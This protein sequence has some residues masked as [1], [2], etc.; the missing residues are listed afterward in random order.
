MPATLW[1]IET[2][3]A[4]RGV[5]SG[6]S[7]ARR[8]ASMDLPAPGGPISSR[9]CPPAAAIS[10]AR[11]AVSIPRTS[12]RSGIFPPSASPAGSGGEST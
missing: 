4:S 2:S 1:I 10:N 6:S 8:A 12:A 7:P 5:R 9:L 11:L 3:N